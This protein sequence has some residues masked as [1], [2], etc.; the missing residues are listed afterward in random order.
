M[1]QKAFTKEYADEL[2]Q[3]IETNLGLYI[4]DGFDYKKDAVVDLH[5]DAPDNLLE[6]MRPY[7]S[8]SASIEVD[9]AIKLYE[10]YKDLTPLEASYKPFGCIYRTLR[11]IHICIKGGLKIKKLTTSS[12]VSVRIGSIKMA[13]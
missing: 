6:D 13:Y 2:M 3:N 7:I 4:K 8:S 1:K 5:F 10:A 11:Y 9:A 12:L